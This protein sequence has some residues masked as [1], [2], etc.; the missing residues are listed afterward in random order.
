MHIILIILIVIAAYFFLVFF[1]LRLV[2][3]YMGFK[4]YA[5][6]ENLPEEMRQKIAE[7][8]NRTSTPSEYLQETYNLVL[9]KTLHQWKHG[10]LQAGIKLHR[11]F[12]KDLAEIWRT[13]KFVYCQA[14]NC[15]VF[16][17]LAKSKFFT[18]DDVKIR[19][20]FLNFVPHQYLLV[21]INNEWIDVDPAGAGI[22]GNG[23]GS[24]AEWF[25]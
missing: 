6:P 2:A 19:H 8:E 14:I 9:D 12:V 11:L 21:K 23:L 17:L 16:A 18:A 5:L 24:H 15:V 10:R 4:R 13:P 20:V 22:R 3:P 25:G 1:V 7:L